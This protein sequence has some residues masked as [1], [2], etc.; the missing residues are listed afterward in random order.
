VIA[1]YDSEWGY[2]NR[3]VELAQKV[4]VRAHA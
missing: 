4:L 3:C 2:S 1:W